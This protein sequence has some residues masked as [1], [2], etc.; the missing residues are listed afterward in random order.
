MS[1]EAELGPRSEPV[2]ARARRPLPRLAE[3]RALAR[4]GVHA[5]ID[6]S[7]GLA[8]DAGHLGEAAGAQLR[9]DLDAVP[10]HAGVAE[11]A[12]ALGR[13][14]WELAVSGGEDYELCFC[15]SAQDRARIE[16]AVAALGAVEVSWVGE[17]RAGAPGASFSGEG[18][19]R[20]GVEGFEHRW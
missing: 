10:L 12:A 9:I 20:A 11:V 5:M 3:G 17:V 14:A 2:L 8:T 6:L 1:G 19:E 4:A 13:P 7:D 16:R 18:G 15:A